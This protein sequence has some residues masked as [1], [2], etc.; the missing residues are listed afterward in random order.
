MQLIFLC[1]DLGEL[2]LFSCCFTKLIGTRMAD[3]IN[4]L[5]GAPLTNTVP[6]YELKWVEMGA[7]RSE[8]QG[9]A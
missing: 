5:S 8:E 3:Y 9:D 6:C 7:V 1:S 4:F 2:D